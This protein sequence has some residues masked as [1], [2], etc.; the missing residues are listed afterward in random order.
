MSLAVARNK[1][2]KTAL[3]LLAQTPSAF[4]NENSKGWSKLI[5][6]SKLFFAKK[7]KKKMQVLSIVMYGY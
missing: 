4:A 1:D 2:G 3:H 7:G 5:Q 6:S